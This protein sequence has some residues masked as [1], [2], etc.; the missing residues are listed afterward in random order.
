MCANIDAC[1]DLAHQLAAY[2]V[3]KM[4]RLGQSLDGTEW[5]ASNSA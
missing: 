3:R 4:S 5:D 2:T 1:E